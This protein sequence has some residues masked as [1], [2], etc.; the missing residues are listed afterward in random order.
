MPVILAPESYA[1]W[2]DCSARDLEELRALLAPF[3]AAAMK[4]YPVSAHVNNAAF[5]D[6]ACL[7]PA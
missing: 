7:A 3:P 1:R 2:L 5:D 4:A 6:P